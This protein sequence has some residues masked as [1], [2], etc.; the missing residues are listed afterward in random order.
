M[1][2]S[3]R[4]EERK[5][6]TNEQASKQDRS[7]RIAEKSKEVMMFVFSTGLLPGHAGDGG[8]NDD[9]SGGG[10]DFSAM[11]GYNKDEDPQKI[12]E[13][14]DR[15]YKKWPG[16]KFDPFNHPVNSVADVSEVEIGV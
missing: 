11:D 10:G 8:K 9:G 3:G 4:K 7:G 16:E 15:Y 12:K 6:Q 13:E 14:V 5:K 1:E 2:K